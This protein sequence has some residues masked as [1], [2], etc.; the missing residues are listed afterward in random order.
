MIPIHES[1]ARMITFRFHS[2]WCVLQFGSFV[3]QGKVSA[4]RGLSFDPEGVRP[5]QMRRNDPHCML[6]V[7]LSL[8]L[9]KD[10]WKMI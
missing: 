6:I 5:N 9:H 1:N 2:S 7:D 4:S 3:G 10:K 8:V